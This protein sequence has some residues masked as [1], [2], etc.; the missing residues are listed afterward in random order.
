M[1]IEQIQ[2]ILMAAFPH[3]EIEEPTLKL[4]RLMWAD[5]PL[6]VLEAAA[7]QY[8]ATNKFYPTVAELRDI[9]LQIARPEIPSAIEAWGE[10]EKQMVSIGHVGVPQFSHPLIGA[11]VKYLGGWKK[12]CLSENGVADRARFIDGYKQLEV[13]EQKEMQMLPQVKELTKRLEAGNAPPDNQA[14]S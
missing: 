8:I 13:R 12:L 4:Q 6:D 2:A 1:N 5:I 7:K 11:M 9:A 14:P 3:Q 10:V